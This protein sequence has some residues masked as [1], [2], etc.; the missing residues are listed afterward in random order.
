MS[1][2]KPLP[3][4]DLGFGTNGTTINKV[5]GS[6]L[7]ES[8]S[9]KNKSLGLNGTVEPVEPQNNQVTEDQSLKKIGGVEVATEDISRDILSPEA[10]GMIKCQNCTYWWER[11]RH[12]TLFNGRWPVFEDDRWRRCKGY[13]PKKQSQ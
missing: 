6:V 12:P 2:F 10:L 3:P 11:C 13:E 9:S 5:S 7:N 4:D 8:N 1:R